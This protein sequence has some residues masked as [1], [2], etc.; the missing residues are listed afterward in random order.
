MAMGDQHPQRLAG[1][2]SGIEVSVG[3]TKLP[4]KAQKR[5]HRGQTSQRTSAPLEVKTEK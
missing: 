2:H 4:K 1:G 5:V 3:R